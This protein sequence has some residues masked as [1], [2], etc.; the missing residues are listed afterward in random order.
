MLTTEELIGYRARAL[1][2]HRVHVA[3]MRKC[4]SAEKQAHLMKYE[5]DHRN[6]IDDRIYGPGDLVL[7]RNSVIKSSMSR[8]MRPRYLGPV[9]VI[10][11]SKGGSYIV[12]ELD[13]SVWQNKVGAFR[14]IAYF[15]RRKI[16]LEEEI[17]HLIDLNKEGLDKLDKEGLEDCTDSNDYTF[18]GVN[19]DETGLDEEG[20]GSEVDNDGLS[21]EDN[22]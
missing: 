21:E 15:A 18:E 7:V 4:V 22:F 6:K 13:G 3:D 5:K 12:C 20:Y 2:K 9:I 16:H 10:C 19:L 1:A 17:G 14:I 8:K 11:H